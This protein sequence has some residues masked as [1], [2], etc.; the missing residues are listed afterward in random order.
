MLRATSAWD[1]GRLA[2]QAPSAA[3]TLGGLQVSKERSPFALI[4]G[5]TP[6]VP[7]KSLRLPLK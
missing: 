6:A 2:R 7:G 3:Q 1:R 4:A 5:E